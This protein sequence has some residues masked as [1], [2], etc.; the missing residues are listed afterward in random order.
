M[1]QGEAQW[2]VGQGTVVLSLPWSC[3]TRELW[4]AAGKSRFLGSPRLVLRSATGYSE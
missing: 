2:P 4:E 3:T 1:T